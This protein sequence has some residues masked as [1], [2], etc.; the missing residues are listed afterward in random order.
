VIH[1]KERQMAATVAVLGTGTMG[2]P[3]ARNLL[4]AGF[5]VRA[6]NRTPGK[7]AALAEAGAT[8]ADTPAAAARGADIVLTMLYDTDS[9]ASVV[10]EALAELGPDGLWLQMT[11]VGPE[12]ARGLQDLAD[13]FGVP[14]VDAPVLGTRAPAEKGSLTVLAAGPEAVRQR[15]ASLFDVIGDRTI[16]V[17]GIQGG[18]RLKLVVNSWVLTVTEA[19]AEALRLASGIGLDPAL[20][21][22]AISG[23]ANDLPYAQAKAHAIRGADFTASFAVENALKDAHLILEAG[24]AAGVDVGLTAIVHRHLQHASDL[25]YGRWDVSA[26]ALA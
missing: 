26:L 17:E 11:T 21:S 8:I 24:A 2:E 1:D 22:E 9:V 20:F 12:G 4:R 19:V 3:M 14:M 23:T 16:W 15:S 6:W 10:P 13:R 5:A 7:T 18:Q 25:G